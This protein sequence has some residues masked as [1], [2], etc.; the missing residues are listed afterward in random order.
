MLLTLINVIDPDGNDIYILTWF[1]K[2]DKTGHGI[3]VDNYKT[4]KMPMEM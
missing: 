2:N 4:I 3:A 1:S